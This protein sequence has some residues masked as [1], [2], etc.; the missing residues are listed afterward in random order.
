MQMKNGPAGAGRI[1][2]DIVTDNRP[3]HFR[4]MHPQLMSATGNRLEREP[5]ESRTPSQ[6]GPCA[7]RR[8][9]SLV[10]LHPPASRF[11]A[12]GKRNVDSPFWGLWSTFDDRPIAFANL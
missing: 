11:V 8:Q 12:L 1:A 10:G 7:G 5:A 3:S 6:D 2:V 9:P 4:A